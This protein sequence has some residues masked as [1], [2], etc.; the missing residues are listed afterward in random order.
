MEVDSA[1]PFLYGS[2]QIVVKTNKLGYHN[3]SIA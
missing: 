2:A 1:L 3:F